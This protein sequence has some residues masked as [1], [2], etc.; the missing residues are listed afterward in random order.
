M[1]KW[2][3]QDKG[4]SEIGGIRNQLGE[5]QNRL[6]ELAAASNQLREEVAQGT[7][8][9]LVAQTTGITGAIDYGMELWR[10]VAAKPLGDPTKVGYTKEALTWIHDH[11]MGSQETE[12][13]KRIE[14]EAGGDGLIVAAS[15]VAKARSGCCWTHLTSEHVRKVF[16]YY[17]LYEAELLALR[18]NYMHTRP[19]TYSADDIKGQIESV[20]K[21][22]GTEDKPDSGTQEKDLLKPSPP[23]C[24][25]QY[26]PRPLGGS[27]KYLKTPFMAEPRSSLIWDTSRLCEKESASQARYFSAPPGWRLATAGEVQRLIAGWHGVNWADWLDSEVGGQIESVKYLTCLGVWTEVGNTFTAVNSDGSEQRGTLSQFPTQLHGELL[28]KDRTEDY[29]W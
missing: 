20:Q 24:N 3:L 12:L 10:E 9:G 28:V 23:C 7:Y 8:S 1:D 4:E 25:T 29:W 13:A 19:D 17:Q 21:L 14:G 11:L 16:D 5:I 18:V 27:P 22:I 2:G 15:K 6:S 26:N